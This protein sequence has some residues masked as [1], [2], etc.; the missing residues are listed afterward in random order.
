MLKQL[1]PLN[2][3][4]RLQHDN[5]R[6]SHDAEPESG[7]AVRP[8]R[9]CTV[10]QPDNVASERNAL[11]NARTRSHPDESLKTFRDQPGYAPQ[12][13]RAHCF[14]VLRKYHP[15]A[16]SIG[17]RSRARHLH[18]IIVPIRPCRRSFCSRPY[19]YYPYR[20]TVDG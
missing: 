13:G 2:K 5:V 14:A 19:V 6:P 7:I 8:N 18:R 16:G 11:T 9:A 17:F 1:C 3:T 20:A 10:G 4:S 15:A 12:Y